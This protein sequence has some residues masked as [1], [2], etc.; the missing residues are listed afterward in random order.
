MAQP[1]PPLKTGGELVAKALAANG[2]RHIYCVPGESYLAVLDALYDVD[3]IAVTVCRQ[4][5]GAAMMAQAHGKL[6][7]Q[8]GICMVTRGP[9]ATNAASGVHVAAQDSTPM[10]L[11]VG[12]VARGDQEREAFQEIDYRAMFGTIAKWVAQIDDAARVPEFIARAFATA[13]GGRPGPVVL[14]LPEDMLRDRVAER[15]IQPVTP[16]VQY[17]GADQIDDMAQMLEQAKRPL[18][19]LGHAGWSAEAIADFRRFAESW[20]LPVAAAFRAQDTFN[21][22]HQN[23]AGDVGI[24]INPALARRVREADVLLVVGARLGEMTT[25]GFTLLDI[26]L[27]RQKLIHVHPGA[28]ELGRI[29]QP[30]L[31]IN[32]TLPAFASM[33]ARH[34]APG[35]VTWSD[36]TKAA[37]ADFIAWTQPVPMP[38]PVQMCAVM[39]QLRARLPDDAIVCNGAGNYAG[40]LHRFYRY[41]EWGG[42]LAPTS[43]SMGY[44][45]PG[46]IAAARAAPS[47]TVVAFAGDGCAMMTIQELATAVQYQL[48]LVL[49]V[50]NNAMLGTIRM[51]QEKNYPGR[52]IATGL[53]NPDFAALAEAF[54]VDGQTVRATDEFA[55]ALDRALGVDGPALIE[56]HIDPQAIST[57]T[58]LSALRAG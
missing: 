50:V 58:T 12:Q 24:A 34:P 4:E 31:A 43:G 54:G 14:A 15:S 27:P 53:T 1:D 48:K 8:P 40:W 3:E 38:G 18:A 20:S 45:L 46:A 5:G 47:R 52:V 55:P 23:Y 42:Q 57:T 19:I 29:Y 39:A 44:G 32:A 9:G 13:T 21:N 56:I 16:L 10:I 26:P 17:P 37:R 6:T 7:G 30:A 11:L 33:A 28:E 51:H 41:R 35:K 36:E 49:I 25:S 2:V 22:D